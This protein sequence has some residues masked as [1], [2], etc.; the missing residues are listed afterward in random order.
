MSYE[1]IEQ[2]PK[3]ALERYKK[4]LELIGSFDHILFLYTS[5]T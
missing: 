1:Y 5:Y 3:E 4:K 2:L